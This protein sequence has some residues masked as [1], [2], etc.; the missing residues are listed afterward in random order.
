MA[1]LL[2][3]AE[4]PINLSL[5]VVLVKYLRALLRT[6]LYG[7]NY[8]QVVEELLRQRIAQL[9]DSEKLKLQD[10]ELISESE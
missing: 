3:T 2:K 7:A 8:S 9:I 4:K 1:N 5:N 6:G 10:E